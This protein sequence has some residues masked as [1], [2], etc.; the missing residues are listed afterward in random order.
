MVHSDNQAGT[1]AAAALHPAIATVGELRA[2][3]HRYEAVK[4]EI[5]RNLS[6]AGY[7]LEDY[8]RLQGMTLDQYREQ[9]RPQAE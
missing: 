2:S 7:G 9:L 5:R 8:V 1:T 4:D 3:G 6:R